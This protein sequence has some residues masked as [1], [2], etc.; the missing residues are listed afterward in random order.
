MGEVSIGKRGLGVKKKIPQNM[1][2]SCEADW[3]REESIG[4]GTQARLS[5]SGAEKIGIS[6]LLRE[7]FPLEP[8]GVRNV[9]S[10]ATS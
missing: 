1:E 4:S 7:S 8:P 5:P 3:A 2:A 9:G 10:E 6:A